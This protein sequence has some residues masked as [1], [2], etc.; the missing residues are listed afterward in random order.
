[1]IP[2]Y[3]IWLFIEPASLFYNYENSM[4]FFPTIDLVLNA[5]ITIWCLVIAIPIVSEVHKIPYWKSFFT[6]LISS[7]I[8]F[9]LIIVPIL[10][11]IISISVWLWVC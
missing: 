6:L 7:L 1:M 5:I 9:L 11:I 2:F 10:M 3:L 8:L 4:F